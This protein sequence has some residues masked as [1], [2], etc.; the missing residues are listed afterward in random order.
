MES[1][2][3]T[4]LEFS[5]AWSQLQGRRNKHSPCHIS[6][7][8]KFPT[9]LRSVSTPNHRWGNRH[10]GEVTHYSRAGIWAHVCLFLQL[11]LPVHHHIVS[12]GTGSLG[13]TVYE[14]LGFRLTYT[15]LTLLRYGWAPLI[16]VFGRER[17][18]GY[19]V[20]PCLEKKRKRIWWI[21]VIL[22]KGT[23]TNRS[24]EQPRS[25]MVSDWPEQMLLIASD[26]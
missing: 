12:S 3:L 7:H 18:M 4:P 15:V 17:Q 13:W 2:T 25:G 23:G 5:K 19:T 26:L 6:S 20:R 11:L 10:W 9:T 1:R 21:K 8:V 14:G 22:G 24:L 16:S